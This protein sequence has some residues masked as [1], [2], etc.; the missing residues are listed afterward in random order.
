MS[1]GV[2]AW[3]HPRVAG[4]EEMLKAADDALYVAKEC[5]RNRVVLFDSEEFNQH[6]EAENEAHGEKS[7]PGSADRPAGA[8]VAVE[9]HP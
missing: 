2:A 6:T 7:E 1:C 3:P 9:G 8:S 4:R 5:G